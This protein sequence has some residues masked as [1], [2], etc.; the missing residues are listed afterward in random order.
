MKIDYAASRKIVIA[1][2]GLYAVIALFLFIEHDDY[3]LYVIQ[4]ETFLHG[5]LD[6]TYPPAF[7]IV[8]APMYA[9]WYK[10]PKLVFVLA[11]V[12]TTLQMHEHLFTHPDFSH[13]SDRQKYM[14]VMLFFIICPN[15]WW[16][17]WVGL[18]DALVGLF[19]FNMYLVLKKRGMARWLKDVVLLGLI[20]AITMIKFTGIFLAVPFLFL[21]TLEARDGETPAAFEK[22]RR[23]GEIFRILFY[24]GAAAVVLAG[25]FL[26]LDVSAGAST[27][28]CTST[29]VSRTPR[30]S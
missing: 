5:S 16:H 22:R 17:V 2:L 19:F 26:F 8:F 15:I 1:S 3:K 20:F 12:V 27:R 14:F 23:K 30:S 28:P 21:N 9:L 13:M 11:F 18:F 6:P 24:G 10:L 25:A 4:W 29:A 7:S